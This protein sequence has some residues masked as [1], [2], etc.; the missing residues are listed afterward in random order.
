MIVRSSSSLLV[1]VAVFWDWAYTDASMNN[2]GCGENTKCTKGCGVGWDRETSK[3]GVQNYTMF[4]AF[5]TCKIGKCESWTDA[6][7]NDITSS[8][9]SE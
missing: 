2:K 4:V 5:K 3:K 9:L 8:L 6:F 7:S 1:F